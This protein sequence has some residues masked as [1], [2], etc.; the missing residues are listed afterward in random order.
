M[1]IKGKV[2]KFGSDINTDDIIAAK[3]LV[4]TDEKELGRHCM[5]NI[6]GDFASIVNKGDIIVVANG[7][8]PDSGDV[9]I[10]TIPDQADPIIHRVV[11]VSGSDGHKVY[12]TKGDHN[13]GTNPFE[14]KIESDQI[15]GK[16][17][18]RVPWLG[19]VKLAFMW[20]VSLI[21]DLMNI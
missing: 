12:K 13:C 9:I 14:E 4:S 15:V 21:A 1:I 19:W 18:V 7:S 16:A 6:A 10:Y 3:Y 20:I 17:R 8:N 11:E 5:E 2:H